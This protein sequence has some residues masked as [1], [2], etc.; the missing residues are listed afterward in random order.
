MASKRRTG[1]REGESYRLFVIIVTV[2]G[3]VPMS[4]E[5][6]KKVLKKQRRSKEGLLGK[7]GSLS[8]EAA[9]QY[10]AGRSM[11][12]SFFGVMRFL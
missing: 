8:P 3:A 4:M 6:G 11:R 9:F 5:M 10:L 2:R 7:D 1:H 12:W